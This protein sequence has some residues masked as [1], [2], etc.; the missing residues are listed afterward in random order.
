[1]PQQSIK[2]RLQS[3]GS[4]LSDDGR[5]LVQDLGNGDALRVFNSRQGRSW[6]V[7]WNRDAQCWQLKGPVSLE[8]T[9]EQKREGNDY[10]VISS[11]S[12]RTL[13]QLREMGAENIHENRMTIDEIAVQIL[14]E[15]IYVADS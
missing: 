6:I 11:D 1:M 8:A 13:R 14:K 9:V 3:Y 2:V 10:Q 12:E 4:Y 7:P 15:G 5:T